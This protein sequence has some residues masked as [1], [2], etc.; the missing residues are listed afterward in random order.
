M[1]GTTSRVDTKKFLIL[2]GSIRFQAIPACKNRRT[3]FPTED[4]HFLYCLLLHTTQ[5]FRP[6]KGYLPFF[7]EV[8]FFA[9]LGRKKN[10]VM[11]LE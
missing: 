5:D 1:P 3:D 11:D 6:I 9:S 10:E 7:R 2:S 4:G 8:P